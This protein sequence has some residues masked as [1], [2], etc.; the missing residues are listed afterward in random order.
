MGLS[1]IAYIIEVPELEELKVVVEK[2]GYFYASLEEVLISKKFKSFRTTRDLISN[3]AKKVSGEI[4]QRRSERYSTGF[5][6]NM[7]FCKF[8]SRV[9]RPL[10]ASLSYD[11]SNKSS[12]IAG[13][14]N[15]FS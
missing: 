7:D 1:K 9:A 15:Y 13:F 2:P 3:F 12:V 5:Y 6:A 14:I 10:R 8:L 4:V 11:N